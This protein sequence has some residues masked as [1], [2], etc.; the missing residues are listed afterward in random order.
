M[1]HT[2]AIL[3][4]LI[5]AVGFLLGMFVA[6]IEIVRRKEKHHY[7]QELGHPDELPEDLRK[8]N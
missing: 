7:E 8:R 2:L 4:L 5:F 3:G 1:N 6:H